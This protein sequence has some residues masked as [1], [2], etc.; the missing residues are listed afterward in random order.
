MESERVGFPPITSNGGRNGFRK[1][2]VTLVDRNPPADHY[3]A[4]DIHAPLTSAALIQPPLH[5]GI[6]L[7]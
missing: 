6:F 2:C 7:E 1:G 3:F 4:R 5:A